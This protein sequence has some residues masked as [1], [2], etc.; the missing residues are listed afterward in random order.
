VLA[1]ALFWMPATPASAL[2]CGSKVK[3]ST[4][5]RADLGC[6]GT[7]LRIAGDGVTLD[8]GGHSV[9]GAIDT[10]G[11]AGV[12]ISDGTLTGDVR[13]ERVVGA[14]VRRLHVR[15]G[16]IECLRSAGCVIAGNVVEGGGILIDRSAIGIPNRIRGNVVSG[17]PAAAIAV[18]RTDTTQVTRNS[19][20]DS[21]IGISMSHSA[22]L[23]IAR[24]TISRNSGPGLSGNFG[25]SAVIVRNYI[26]ANGSD[27]ISLRTWG[28]ETQIA[29]NVTARNRG[30]GIYGF[31]VAHW[32]VTAN[33]ALRNRASGIV[34]TGAVEEATLAAN[35]AERNGELGIDAGPG[36]L[37]GGANRAFLNRAPAQCAGIAC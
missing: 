34:I 20:R 7:A 6:H 28:G 14:S 15:G 19:V 17:A 35:R 22:D 27:G 13:I 2:T 23:L 31:V 33:L 29:H 21:A 37:D 36:V 9:R 3:A 1:A 18:G 10:T 8:L 30:S 16:S 25:T 26:T 11:H 5:L 32:H 4:V 24:N 12:S